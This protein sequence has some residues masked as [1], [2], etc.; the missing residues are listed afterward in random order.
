MVSDLEQAI[1]APQQVADEANTPS[2]PFPLPSESTF[3]LPHP[4]V[5]S[6]LPW[7]E[8]A[9][10][11]DLGLLNTSPPLFP[12]DMPLSDPDLQVTDVK[13]RI[14]LEDSGSSSSHT[15]TR[16]TPLPVMLNSKIESQQ[17]SCTPGPKARKDFI[18]EFHEATQVD[19]AQAQQEAQYYHAQQMARLEL[20]KEKMR[21]K[22]EIESL[23]LQLQLAQAQPQQEHPFPHY[24]EYHQ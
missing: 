1:S 4:H 6:P 23:K 9:P 12:I 7:T 24:M 13:P 18:A 20:K 16:A 14:D 22:Y 2:D 3:E 15:L 17:T 5:N 19:Q 8:P 10:Q 11:A 21:H